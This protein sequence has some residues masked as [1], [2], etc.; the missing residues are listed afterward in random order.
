[1]TQTSV[2]AE[3]LTG[4]KETGKANQ[5]WKFIYADEQM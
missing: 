2:F 5:K 4:Y 3:E 1:M